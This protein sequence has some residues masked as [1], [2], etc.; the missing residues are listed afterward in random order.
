MQLGGVGGWVAGGSPDQL[1]Q[2]CQDLSKSAF[3]GRGGGD[4]DHLTNTIRV[5]RLMNY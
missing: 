4:P 3:S 5:W 1:N 2:N